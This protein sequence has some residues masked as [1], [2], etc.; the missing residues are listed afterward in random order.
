MIAP[1]AAIPCAATPLQQLR[2]PLQ[3]RLRTLPDGASTL[4]DPLLSTPLLIRTS[5]YMSLPRLTSGIA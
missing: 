3:Q 5:P 1:G 2:W 4:S